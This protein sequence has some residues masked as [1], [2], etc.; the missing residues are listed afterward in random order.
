MTN[1]APSSQLPRRIRLA[2]VAAATVGLGLLVHRAGDGVLGDIAGD[3]LYA[4]LIYLLCAIVAPW[5]RRPI[6]AGIALTICIAVELLQLTRLPRDL[7][8]VFPPAELA[9][10][11]GFDTRDLVVYAAAVSAAFLVDTVLARALTHHASGNAAGRPPEG[12]RP[13]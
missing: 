8:A 6:V 11:S 13:V 10:G 7:A 1:A 5:A 2:L 4:L 12:E 3:A 9:L